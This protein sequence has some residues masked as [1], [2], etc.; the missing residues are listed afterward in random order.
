MGRQRERDPVDR[1][2]DGSYRPGRHGALEAPPLEGAQ[3][4]EVP[5]DLEDYRE[6]WETIIAD[7]KARGLFGLGDLSLLADGLR[8][9]RTARRIQEGIDKCTDVE[10]LSKMQRAFSSAHARASAVFASFG[11]GTPVNRAKVRAPKDS[12]TPR[13]YLDR[14]REKGEP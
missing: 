4:A 2:A 11:I 13:D 1:V 12:A 14:M 7:L 6:T 5:E 10:I 3:D 8:Q 9:L